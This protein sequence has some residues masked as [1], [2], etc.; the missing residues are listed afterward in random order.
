M[1]YAII[2]MPSCPVFGSTKRSKNKNISFYQIPGE[3]RDKIQRK[4]CKREGLLQAD[5]SFNFYIC[6]QHF[7]ENCFQRD[8]KISQKQ[9]LKGVPCSKYS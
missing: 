1:V 9:S 5:K 8:L 4:M 2:N 7:V 3:K 6:A